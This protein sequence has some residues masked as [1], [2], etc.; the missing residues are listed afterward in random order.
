[1]N[2]YSTI[3]NTSLATIIVAA[4]AGIVSNALA[5]DQK[6]VYERDVRDDIRHHRATRGRGHGF[7]A[8][9]VS[10]QTSAGPQLRSHCRSI[11]TLPSSPPARDTM[12]ANLWPGTSLQWARVPDPG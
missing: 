10:A 8:R 6:I 2:A 11:V 12:T 7:A 4:L 5:V 1:M 9:V 3:R